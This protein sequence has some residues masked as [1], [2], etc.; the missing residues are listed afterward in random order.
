MDVSTN[1]HIQGGASARI[2]GL[3]W[4]G[5]TL[6][7]A[8]QFHCLAY[9]ELADGNLVELAEQLGKIVELQNQSQPNPTV[10]A[11]APPCKIHHSS[12]TM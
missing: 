5:L 6:I 8:V 3:G 4:V 7:L 11:D 1:R 9:S 10:Q 2:V 12:S